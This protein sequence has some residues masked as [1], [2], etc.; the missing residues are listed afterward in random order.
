MTP[1][2]TQATKSCTVMAGFVAAIHVF[3]NLR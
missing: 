1:V 2:F 3:V